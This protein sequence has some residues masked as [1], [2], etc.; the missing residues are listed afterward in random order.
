LLQ[1]PGQLLTPEGVQAAVWPGDIAPDP[2]R[3]G[4]VMKTLPTAL[5]QGE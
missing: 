4:S 1:K 5:D 3:A 2:E